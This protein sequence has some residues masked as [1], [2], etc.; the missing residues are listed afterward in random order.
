MAGNLL[1]KQQVKKLAILS[2]VFCSTFSHAMPANEPATLKLDDYQLTSQYKGPDADQRL[3]I[4]ISDLSTEKALFFANLAGTTAAGY[5]VVSL[6][7]DQDKA[8][9]FLAGYVVGN[10]T[11][12]LSQL[13]LDDDVKNRRLVSILIGVASSV[14]VGIGKEVLDSRGHGTASIGDALATGAGGITGSLT[15][16]FDLEKAVL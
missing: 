7:P 16:S 3:G 5:G 2:I 14:L 9:H 1:C 15:L 12:G 13:M 11:N 8:R 4:D 6:S 10:V